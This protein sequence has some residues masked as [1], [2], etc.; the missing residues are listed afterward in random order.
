[1]SNIYNR[2]VDAEHVSPEVV[3]D[4]HDADGTLGQVAGTGTGA[5]AG[6]LL[7][8]VAGGPI[9]AVI[10]AVAGGVLGSAAGDAA[11][12]MGDDQD[13]V[14][15]ITGSGGDV[16]RT[17]GTGLGTISGAAVGTVAGGPVG[18]VVGAVAGGVLGAAAGNGAKDIIHEDGDVVTGD[19]YSADGSLNSGEMVHNNRT[20][21]DLDDDVVVT[22]P[23]SDYDKT[24]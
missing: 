12:H 1:M 15:V 21:S 22:T 20:V 4:A 23:R 6:G 10:G 17:A 11:H 16:G 24:L 9:G 8:A 14:N 19:Q 18:T 7:G 2:D 13:D 3:P 5:V